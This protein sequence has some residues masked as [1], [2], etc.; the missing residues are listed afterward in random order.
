[1]DALHN[2]P[3]AARAQRGAS[4][5]IVTLLLF[6]AMVLTA[7]YVNRNLVFEQRIA[8]NQVRSTLAFEAAEAGLEWAIAQLNNPQRLGPDCLPTT[9]LAATSFRTRHLVFN[10]ADASF[11]PATWASAGTPTALRP[12]CVRSDAGWACSCP[13][14]G[15]PVLVPASGNAPEAAFTLQFLPAGKPGL[16][17][18]SATGCTN[19]AGACV[20]GSTGS[21]D[22]TATL[23]IVLGL[24]PGLRT[25]PAAA[26]TLRGAFDA[27]T[28]TLGVHNPD[29]ATGIAIHA[30]GAIAAAHTRLTV[31]AG[32]STAT[33]LAGHDTVLASL[34]PD[35]FFAAIFGLDK[36]GWKNQPGVTRVDCSADCSGALA[37]AINAAADSA[38]IWVDGDLALGGPLTLGS[39][40]HPVVIV[41]NGAVRL[42]GAVAVSG[43]V[44]A[45]SMRW[46]GS[47]GGAAL[48][49][50]AITEGSYQG[51]GTPEFFYDTA[52]LA[53]LNGNS[54]SFARVS[55]SWR[56]F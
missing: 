20:A 33:A 31:P 37:A 18:V 30:G 9:D 34:A 45:A 42:D 51:D 54:G 11:T 47:N 39:A 15:G 17:R 46:D 10:R 16:V 8:T 55:G 44:Y 1:M 26:L 12:S 43:V 41:V 7:A 56:D 27:D 6:F 29:P 35:R 49:G 21:A 14:N 38:L 22:A 5:L 23:D 53:T 2:P 4:A 24:L 28:A 50:A 48:R 19:L 25:P 3:Q 36:A 32:A 13:A 52:V 40:Q